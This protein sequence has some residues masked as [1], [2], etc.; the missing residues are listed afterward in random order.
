MEN[1]E[2]AI[3]IDPNTVEALAKAG[4]RITFHRETGDIRFM[5]P[6]E[7]QKS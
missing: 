5:S 7:Y 3:S 2:Y 4:Y 6:M 1:D